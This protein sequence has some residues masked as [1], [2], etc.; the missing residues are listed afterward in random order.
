MYRRCCLVWQAP[1]PCMWCIVLPKV[2][3]IFPS[4]ATLSV[5]IKLLHWLCN[6]GNRDHAGGKNPKISGFIIQEILPENVLCSFPFTNQ[7]WS[8][9]SCTNDYKVTITTGESPGW[10]H[11]FAILYSRVILRVFCWE[12]GYTSHTSNCRL[13]AGWFMKTS[14]WPGPEVF[15][16]TPILLCKLRAKIFLRG[17]RFRVLPGSIRDPACLWNSLSLSLSVH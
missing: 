15:E 12:T 14:K 13:Y 8:S 5:T 10:N 1:A 4:L 17:K 9:S 3:A 6:Q 16:G 7:S 11:C 2:L